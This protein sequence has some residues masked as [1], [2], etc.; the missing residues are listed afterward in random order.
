MM[1][2]LKPDKGL[3]RKPSDLQRLALDD[4]LKTEKLE[5]YEVDMGYWHEARYRHHHNKCVVCMAGAVM[6]CEFGIGPDATFVPEK[7]V[8]AARKKLQAIEC[9]R[10]GD[11][12]GAFEYLGRS[13][14][15]IP[16]GLVIP[17]SYELNR[18]QFIKDINYNIRVLRKAGL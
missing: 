9:M 12:T 10:V 11:Y 13:P 16:D 14:D 5:G 15:N 4:T 1:I 17:E 3:P 8:P 6:R 7:F 18:T 2:L